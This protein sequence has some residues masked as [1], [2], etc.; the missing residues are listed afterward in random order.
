[1]LLSVTKKKKKKKTAP[2]LIPTTAGDGALRF[3]SG[4]SSAAGSRRVSVRV[5]GPRPEALASASLALFTASSFAESRSGPSRCS[6][7]S[8]SVVLRVA[9]AAHQKRENVHRFHAFH[10][11]FLK[12]RF[13][14]H[15]SAFYCITLAGGS[16]TPD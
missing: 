13:V 6:Q 9:G 7:P 12:M 3:R 15:R 1:M 4:L 11:F 10:L 8:F 14:N 16:E 5:L 2:R